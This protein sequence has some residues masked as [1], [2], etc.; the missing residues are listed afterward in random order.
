MKQTE[1]RWLEMTKGTRWWIPIWNEDEERNVERE[2]GMVGGMDQRG[3]VG[4]HG[5]KDYLY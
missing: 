3:S 4:W 2:G 5:E 1:G